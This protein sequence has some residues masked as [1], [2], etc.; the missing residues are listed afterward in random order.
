MKPKFA[1]MFAVFIAAVLF[2]QGG[3]DNI[4]LALQEFCQLILSMLPVVVLVMILAAAI[5]YAIGQLL[6]AETRARA[7]VWATAML[8]GAVICVLISVLMPWLL[9]QVYPEAGIENAC[10]IK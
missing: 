7:S 4:K 9:S 2:A 10:A 3:A 6:G 8:T 5:I 1:L